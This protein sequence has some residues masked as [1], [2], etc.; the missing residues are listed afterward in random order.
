M[1]KPLRLW[2][3]LKSPALIVGLFCL[4]LLVGCTKPTNPDDVAIEFWTALA[5][6]D[7]KK[8]KYYS[9]EES[10]QLFRKDMRNASFQIG[11]VKY[12]CDGATVETYISRQSAEASSVFK[13]ILIRDQEQDRWKVDYQRTIDNISEK[14]FKSIITTTEETGKAVNKKVQFKTFFKELWHAI[15]TVFTTLKDRLLS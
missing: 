11:K 8:A 1:I 2:I 14:R 10:P 9:T 3:N 12:V 7:L 15:V 13:T 4:L 5:E 6:N